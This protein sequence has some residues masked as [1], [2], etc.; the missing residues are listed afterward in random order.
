MLDALGQ[1]GDLEFLADLPVDEI[2]DIGVIEI[3][4][5]HFRGPAGGAARLNRTGGA[6][7][8]LEEAHQPAAL[9]TAG[10]GF[11]FSAHFREIGARSAAVLEEARLARPE[12]HDAPLVDEVIADALNEARMRLRALVSAG[13]PFHLAIGGVDVEVALCWAGDVVGVVQT[14]VE[15]LRA[16]GGRHLV[17]EHPGQFI[18]ERRHV[19]GSVEIAV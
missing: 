7:A 16:V 15:P 18:M 17:Q 9:A 11:I 8:D 3:E 6:V 13:R 4:T 10:K 12:V 2:L 5:D 14:G 19:V 1:R